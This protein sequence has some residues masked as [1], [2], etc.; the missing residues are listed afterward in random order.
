MNKLGYISYELFNEILE[1]YKP[2]VPEKK[3]EEDKK[4]K[5]FG[6]KAEQKCISEN[7]QKFVSLVATNVERG[8]ITHSDALSYL[9]IKLK[10]LDKVISKAKR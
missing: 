7:G 2:Q 8:L 5:V 10:N 1:R 4:A 9:S 6:K 3:G